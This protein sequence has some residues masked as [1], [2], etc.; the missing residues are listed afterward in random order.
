MKADFFLRA[1]FARP[2]FLRLKH[3]R[4]ADGRFFLRARFAR[5]Q[6]LNSHPSWPLLALVLKLSVRQQCAVAVKF[7]FAA[8]AR[9]YTA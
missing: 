2:R 8:R 5:P 3:E 7:Y 9:D 4:G 1:R 6:N